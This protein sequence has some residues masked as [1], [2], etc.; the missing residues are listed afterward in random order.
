MRVFLHFAILFALN[1]T[2]GRA[3]SIVTAANLTVSANSIIQGSDGNFYGTANSGGSGLCRSAFGPSS[4]GIVFKLTPAGAMTTLY[5]FQP[6]PNA[7]NTLPFPNSV[8]QASDGNFYGTTERGGKGCTYGCGT[9]FKVTPGG[10]GTILYTFDQVHGA[11]PQDPW[12]KV[13]TE[14]SMGSHPTA[15]PAP[16]VS[17]DAGRSSRSHRKV[18]SLRSIVSISSPTQPLRGAS[19]EQPMANFME[20]PHPAAPAVSARVAI[21]C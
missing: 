12:S 3:Q 18:S 6:G 13:R 11:A 7:A 15:G 17:E 14:T 5:S 10:S 4:C 8:I 2:A 1:A 9:I 21:P 20:Q 19:Y 16:I